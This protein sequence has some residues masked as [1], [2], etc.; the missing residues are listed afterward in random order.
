MRS[1]KAG[2]R[3][4]RDRPWSPPLFPTLLP[5]PT[6][7]GS[8]EALLARTP[9]PPC[10]R[11]LLPLLAVS[12]SVPV[13]CAPP[14][15]PWMGKSSAARRPRGA[16]CPTSFRLLSGRAEAR[17]RGAAPAARGAARAEPDGG[18]SG[19]LLGEPESRRGGRPQPRLPPRGA[20]VISAPSHPHTGSGGKPRAAAG[21]RG[22]RPHR[23]SGEPCPASRHFLSENGARPWGRRRR[24]SG[25][26]S[27]R[28]GSCCLPARWGERWSFPWR[29]GE[30]PPSGGQ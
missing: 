14:S 22:R 28:L 23:E 21:C 19:H 26:A 30:W 16:A 18:A 13:L 15:G 3:R 24:R 17:E 1:G 9:E 12:R 27:S 5:P 2:A 20:P 10:C 8:G 11:R 7:W 25:R 6:R 4:W 29:G